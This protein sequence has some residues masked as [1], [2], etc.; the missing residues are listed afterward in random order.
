MQ[1]R[2]RRR[3]A[4]ISASQRVA[5]CYGGEYIL[6]QDINEDL[7]D[8]DCMSSNQAGSGSANWLWWLVDL[9]G[10]LVATEIVPQAL[11]AKRS[12]RRGRNHRL[13]YCFSSNVPRR[14]KS[15]SRALLCPEALSL[16]IF[17]LRVQTGCDSN[18]L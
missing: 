7:L 14:F 18:S 12:C 2:C 3:T 1:I 9:G 4:K 16:L 15:Y 6:T 8:A 5:S 17:L 11:D 10:I 13:L